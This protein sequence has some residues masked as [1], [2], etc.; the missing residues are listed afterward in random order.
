LIGGLVARIGSTIYDGS[1]RNQLQLLEEK[2][3][4][5]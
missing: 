5:E 1:I 2:L 3:A 4:S